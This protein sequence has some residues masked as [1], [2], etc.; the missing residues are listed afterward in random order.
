MAVRYLAFTSCCPT[1]SMVPGLTDW[2]NL[3]TAG[4]FLR[5]KFKAVWAVVDLISNK[6]D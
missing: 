6:F 4:I 1:I 2:T 5:Y 3:A